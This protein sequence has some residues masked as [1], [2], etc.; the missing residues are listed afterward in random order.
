MRKPEFE[1]LP[2]GMTRRCK[3]IGN[4]GIISVY[5][6]LPGGSSRSR[7]EFEE[8]PNKTLAQEIMHKGFEGWPIRI[9]FTNEGYFVE[10]LADMTNKLVRVEV[11][12]SRHANCLNKA[13]YLKQDLMNLTYLE[14]G[15]AEAV[16][17]P[18]IP[19]SDKMTEK[20]FGL[21]D[22]PDLLNYIKSTSPQKL[23]H[24]RGEEDGAFPS[25]PE[26]IRDAV[27]TAA[28][29][30]AEE[31]MEG[32]S[33]VTMDTEAVEKLLRSVGFHYN[34]AVKILSYIP[35]ESR[36]PFTD[37]SVVLLKLR[38]DEKFL[39]RVIGDVIRDK[40]LDL[41][42]RRIIKEEFK[43]GNFS[44]ECFK[45]G[46]E[47]LPWGSTITRVGYTYQIERDQDYITVTCS[48][49]RKHLWT[50]GFP[51]SVPT[52]RI[53]DIAPDPDANFGKVKDFVQISFSENPPA[54]EIEVIEV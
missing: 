51:A 39:D 52:S 37:L 47:I 44:K 13:E 31:I 54:S 43:L 22:L 9:G 28:L 26:G 25:S 6:T 15:T 36:K 53:L 38:I 34:L 4:S 24:I 17:S 40:V 7:Y 32:I 20:E 27:S 29:N 45:S 33:E 3:P 14:D 1:H 42:D 46:E 30:S 19:P 8:I 41:V 48:K 10:V 23:A 11:F 35:D 5:E 12:G 21:V 18:E 49:G 16:V 50:G 2:W